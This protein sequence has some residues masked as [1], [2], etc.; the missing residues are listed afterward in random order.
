MTQKTLHD[1][2]TK[3][4][5]GSRT[6]VGLTESPGILTPVK[7]YSA[8]TPYT[9][10][11]GQGVSVTALQ[12]ASVYATLANDGVRQ[13]PRLFKA[14][15][16]ADG[17]LHDVPPGPQTR[18]V[19]AK[20]ATSVREMLESVV[21]E[22]G[23]AATAEIPGYRVAGKTGTADFYD[24][25]EGRYNGYTASFIGIAPADKPRLVIAVFLQQPE[26][27]HYGGVLAAPVFK[28]L[29]TYALTREGVPPSG[30][31]APEVSLNWP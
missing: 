7:N 6:G 15:G 18:V 24:E 25:K 14:I 2:L 8:T 9:I 5:Y 19:S 20:T 17:E 30:T 31:E 12:A 21:S 10:M 27:G 3:F 11:F 29:M 28:E 23:T 16:G 1:Y 13:T 22:E 4:G 26:N